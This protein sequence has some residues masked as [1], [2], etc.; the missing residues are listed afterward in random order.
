MFGADDNDEESYLQK[1]VVTSSGRVVGGKRKQADPPLAPPGGWGI[2][3]PTADGQAGSTLLRSKMAMRMLACFIQ[4][5]HTKRPCECLHA[6][7]SRHA[8]VPFLW[9]SFPWNLQ[10]LVD[11]RNV[12]CP[13]ALEYVIPRHLCDDRAVP[14]SAIFLVLLRLV[15]RRM[16]CLQSTR[17]QQWHYRQQP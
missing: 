16:V 5:V 12:E 1:T 9:V 8:T 10:Q 4:Q 7:R 11:N 14:V 3:T 13:R 6:S 2:E 15:S 17:R